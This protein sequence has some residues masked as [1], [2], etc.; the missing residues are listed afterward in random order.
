[1]AR[2]TALFGL[3]LMAVLFGLLCSCGT[4]TN[5][6]GSNSATFQLRVTNAA[7]SGA[8][9]TVT[10]SPSGVNCGSTCSATFNSGTAVTLTATANNGS[11]F[12]GWSGGGCSGAGTCTVVLSAATTVAA[13]FTTSTVMTY[14]L[15]V[16][17]SGTGSGT[18]ASNPAGISCGSTCNAT[19]NGEMA[20]ALTEAANT[21][22]TFT[23]WSGGG[24]SG[25]A[26]TCTVTLSAATT[27][28]ATFNGAGIASLNHIIFL[29]QENRSLDS[30]LG[31]LRDYWAQN[32]FPD[33]S[34]DGLPQF[35]PAT[36]IAPLQG[37]APS[38]PGCDPTSPAPSDCVF[39]TSNPLTSFHLQTMCIENPSPSW[40]EAHVDWDYNDQVGLYPATNN[41][42]VWTAAHDGRELGYYDTDG[43]RA[44]GYYN[45]DDLNFLYFMASNFGTSD[46]WFNPA[47]SRTNINREYLLAATSGGYAYPNG[48]DVADTPQLGSKTI[49]EVL[50]DA[51]ITWKIYV[52]TEGSPC[53]SPPYQASCLMTLSYLQNF[54]Y[55]QTVV[56]QYPQNIAPLSQY[57]SDLNNGT[58]P[59][60]AE[61][62]PP[63]DAGEDEHPS[64][65]DTSPENIQSGEV[66]VQQIIA[67]LMSSSA[68]SSSALFMTYDEWGGI[69]DHVPPQATV[70]PDGIKPVDL[71]PGDVCTQVTG[72]TCDFVYT[73]YRVPLI[74]VS[75][76]AKKNYVSHTVADYTAILKFIETRFTLS[77]LTQRDAAQMDMTEFFDFSNPP[78]ITPPTPPEQST[79]GACYL[80]H[81]P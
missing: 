35:N 31:S 24:C 40:N 8:E 29:A 2:Y 32:G 62:E 44:M 25:T 54:T 57:F 21:G 22:S 43:L 68:W 11:T 17:L 45:G 75:P 78:W 19:F 13:T 56:S 30:Y 10:S 66:N 72:P 37:P 76:Y 16:Q 52:D 28:T 53:S 63:S 71:L 70:S 60:V 50:Q 59:Q 79:N 58:L 9:G 20:V 64:D 15:T 23:G 77:A 69:Y 3:G 80:D 7:A 61:I 46:R 36:G 6:S 74:V 5:S 47:M 51:G 67:S 48:T 41:G 26:T 12:A 1:M 39:D 14:Q 34:F 27:V 38:I 55:A 81:L 49:F 73:G 33:Q 42:F 65:Y 4:S 18:V